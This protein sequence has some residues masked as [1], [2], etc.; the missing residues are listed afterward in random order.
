MVNKVDKRK[1]EVYLSLGSNLG[2][3]RMNL[4]VA[5]ERIEDIVGSVMK[6]SAIYSTQAWGNQ[7]LGEFYNSVIMVYTDL[8]PE[9]LLKE[10]EE[11]ERFGGRK[12]KSV[13]EDYKNRLIDIDILLYD[14]LVMRTEKLIIPHQYILERDFVLIPLLEIN[15]KVIHPELNRGIAGLVDLTEHVN[16]SKIC[17]NA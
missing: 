13:N 17:E 4:K 14:D 12:L 10:I 7:Q 8:Q 1:H 6:K 3:R 15:S 9:D 11:I 5:I 2:D 16:I